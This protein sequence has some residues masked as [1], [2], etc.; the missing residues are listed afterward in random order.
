M[1]EALGSN[2]SCNTP[3]PPKKFSKERTKEECSFKPTHKRTLF[4]NQGQFSS[5][6][7]ANPGLGAAP[8]DLHSSLQPESGSDSFFIS[9]PPSCACTLCTPQG[10]LQ[11]AL[12]P[13]HPLP[14]FPQSILTS[15]AGILLALCP[16]FRFPSSPFSDVHL[17]N[18]YCT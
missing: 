1:R 4:L 15:I 11:E 6:Q 9:S 12:R 3:H 2:R 13:L 5:T 17:Q 14:G 10:H 18:E 8:R 7:S 16:L